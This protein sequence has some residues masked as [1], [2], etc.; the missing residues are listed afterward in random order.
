VFDGLANGAADCS[1]PAIAAHAP[2]PDCSAF[3]GCSLR[4]VCEGVSGAAGACSCAAG[5]ADATCGTATCG[6]GSGHTCVNGVCVRQCDATGLSLPLNT[7]LPVTLYAAGS[8]FA[9]DTLTLSVDESIKYADTDI[10]FGAAVGHCGGAVPMSAWQATAVGFPE[11]VRRWR[12]SVPWAQ[13]NGG[14]ATSG[15]GVSL[16]PA[17]GPEDASLVY[18]GLVRVHNTE[19]ALPGVPR[20]QTHPVPFA[21][22]FPR[23]VAVA[24]A[25]VTAFARVVTVSAV[26]EQSVTVSPAASPAT[27]ALSLRVRTSVQWPFRLSA[28]VLAVK[29]AHVSAAAAPAMELDCGANGLCEQVFLVAGSAPPRSRRATLAARTSCA[30][31]WRPTARWTRR[32][33]QRR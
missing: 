16:A 27:A 19:Q 28:P 31:R 18:R 22:V 10:D 15:C 3:G 17:A 24:T 2:P 33:A 12:V 25:R 5:W 13:A 21:V 23:E 20:A 4:G 11:C 14:S 9:G 6:C 7:T 29:P 30:S 26:T 1:H 32:R 8:G